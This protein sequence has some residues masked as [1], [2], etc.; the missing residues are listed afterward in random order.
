MNTNTLTDQLDEY[1]THLRS[2]NYSP[3]TLKKISLAVMRF[4]RW[5]REA[6]EIETPDRLQIRHMDAYQRHLMNWRTV[7]G[8]PLKPATINVRI[9]SL[10]GFL[11]YLAARGYVLKALPN[12]LQP[13]KLPKRLPESVLTHAQVKKI[14]RQIDTSTPIGYRNRAIIELLYTSALRAKEILALDVGDL[15]F[16]QHTALVHGKGDK[17]RIVPIGRTALRVLESYVVAVRP[18]LAHDPDEHALFVTKW[19]K[20]CR[21]HIIKNWLNRY[22]GGLDLDVRVSSHTFRRSCTTEMIRAGANIYHVKELLGHES[23]ETLRHY[24]RLTINDLKKT[25]E[26]CHPREKDE[27]R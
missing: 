4:L 16:Q 17:D 1:C 18:F 14:I 19:G 3:A 11:R 8:L 12:A 7:K 20:R 6:H 15:D 5:V 10:V 13:V 26:K 9:N 22:T 23:L 27:P 25:H 24:T 21:Y 2:R